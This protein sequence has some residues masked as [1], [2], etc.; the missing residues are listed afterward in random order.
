MGW[1]VAWLFGR[2]N[3]PH[4]DHIKGLWTLVTR[5]KQSIPI[6]SQVRVKEMVLLVV[7]MLEGGL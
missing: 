4:P 2:N 1:H 3:D 5:E 6:K 7:F